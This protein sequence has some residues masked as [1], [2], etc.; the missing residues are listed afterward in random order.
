M[1]TDKDIY[2]HLKNGGSIED[3]KKALENEVQATLDRIIK[4]KDAELK[5]QEAKKKE[6]KAHKAA[7][8]A[9]KSYFAL[10]NP[11][12]DDKMIDIALDTLKNINIEI[13]VT[14]GGKKISVKGAW[15]DDSFFKFP[16]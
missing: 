3:L 10:V 12:V 8:S 7:V 5:A 2:N 1:L 13:K 9:M 16:F 15:D 11:K 14:D 4:E 6:D